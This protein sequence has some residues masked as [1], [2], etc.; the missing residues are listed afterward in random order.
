MLSTLTIPPLPFSDTLVTVNSVF[1][2]HGLGSNPDSAWTARR[3]GTEVRWLRDLLPR[4]EGVGHMRVAM[5]NHQTRWDANTA[6]MRFEDHAAM[7]LED[8][9]NMREV[10]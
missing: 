6:N 1:A 4:V 2:I 8:I 7:I 10:S 3:N 5:V 9:E